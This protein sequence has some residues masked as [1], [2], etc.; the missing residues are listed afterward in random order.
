M[1]LQAA[2]IPICADRRH[3]NSVS[4]TV[5]LRCDDGFDVGM[6]SPLGLR[7]PPAALPYAA[8]AFLGT[9]KIYQLIGTDVAWQVV[10]IMTQYTVIHKPADAM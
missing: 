2:D 9:G 5:M 3:D 10:A 8:G 6:T 7:A 4:N 1:S